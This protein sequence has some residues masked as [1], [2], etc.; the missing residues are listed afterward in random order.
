MPEGDRNTLGGTMRLGS[1]RTLLSPLSLASRLY[2]GSTAVYER[3]RHRY[4]VNPSLVPRLEEC[5]MTFSGRDETNTRMEIVELSQE[6]HP[7][8]VGVQF[9]PEFK[10][11]PLRPAPTF[12]GLVEAAKS[13]REQL[14]R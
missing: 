2:G 13:Y 8:F 6:L 4:E 11:R 12:L 14:R 9:H 10:S 7:Y 3:H 5:G 1:R